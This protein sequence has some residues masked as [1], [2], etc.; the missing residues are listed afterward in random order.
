MATPPRQRIDPLNSATPIVDPETGK[1]TIQFMRLWQ[2]LFSNEDGT[3]EEAAQAL[4]DAQ[5]AQADIDAAQPRLLPPGGAT[6][7]VLAKVSATDYD[8]AWTPS[9]SGAAWTQVGIWS[10]STNVP[11]VDFTGLAGYT[12]FRLYGINLGS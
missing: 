2:Q 4:A 1:P 12:D 5:A 8:V 6:S 9:A 11:N 3:N 7:E 10:W